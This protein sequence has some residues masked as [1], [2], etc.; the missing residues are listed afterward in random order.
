[1]NSPSSRRPCT[2]GRQGSSALAQPGAEPGPVK[3]SHGPVA[4]RIRLKNMVS[5]SAST[6]SAVS[7]TRC[8]PRPAGPSK[9][10]RGWGPILSTKTWTARPTPPT[11]C[12]RSWPNASRAA[13]PG[14][15][16]WWGMCRRACR[17]P[18]AALSRGVGGPCSGASARL[19]PSALD[20]IDRLL[21]DGGFFQ[22][23]IPCEGSLAYSMARKI[24]A[25]ALFLNGTL[26]CPTAP[27]S[28]PSTST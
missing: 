3:N 27:S 9:L 22:V 15:K 20:E 7:S 18:M 6:M 11:K 13:F 5:L 21:A 1:M 14:R 17:L 25:Q 28:L 12:A 4:A 23:V 16:C 24:S 10:G 8:R 2:N 19:C 26:R